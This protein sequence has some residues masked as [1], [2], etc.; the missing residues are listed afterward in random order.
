PPVIYPLSLHAALPIYL[1][2]VRSGSHVDDRVVAVA[3]QFRVVPAAAQVV[4]E[5]LVGGGAHPRRPVLSVGV[6]DQVDGDLLPV[7]LVV[8]DAAVDRPPVVHG[9]EEPVLQGDVA[10][11]ADDAP[12]VGGGVAGV[13]AVVVAG[14]RGRGHPA[15]NRSADQQGQL[16][17]HVHDPAQDADRGQS[18]ALGDDG[19]F[20]AAEAACLGP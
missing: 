9:V 14:G 11:L 4:A 1:V 17:Q 12:V 5:V 3:V 16:H 19:A 2:G 7:G 13:D 15:G 20:P 18:A 6:L 8:V 10:A